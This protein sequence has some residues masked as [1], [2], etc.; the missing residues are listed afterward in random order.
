MDRQAFL[1]AT[2]QGSWR[3]KADLM[4]ILVIGG[5]LLQFRCVFTRPIRP[6]SSSRQHPGESTRPPRAMMTGAWIAS[7]PVGPGERI[8]QQSQIEAILMERMPGFLDQLFKRNA[9][10]EYPY[11]GAL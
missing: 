2:L 8:D 10:R 4:G 5:V 1:A 11:A 3:R 7:A 6:V 9:Y